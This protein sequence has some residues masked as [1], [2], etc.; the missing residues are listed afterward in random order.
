M[1]RDVRI[2]PG[3]GGRT[4]RFAFGAIVA[5]G[6]LLALAETFLRLSPP[7]DL[8]PYL[9]EASPLRGIYASDPEC[10]VTYQNWESFCTDNAERLSPY[11][12]FRNHPDG[13][14]LWAFFGNSFVQAPGMLADTTRAHVSD[15]T[16]F[17]LGRNE[18]LPLRFAQVKLLLARGLRPERIFFLLMPVDTVGLGKQPLDTLLV[19][20]RGALTY[21]LQAPSGPAGWLL[22]NSRVALTAWV[23][24]GRQQGNPHFDH[25]N[26]Y[27]MVDPVL[28]A[29]LQHLFA[30]L[31]RHGKKHGVPVTVL[32]VPAWHQVVRGESFGFQDTLGPILR[33]LGLD[34]FDPR[35]TF[36]KHPEPESLFLPDKHFNDQG[37]RILLEALLRHIGY[38]GEPPPALTDARSP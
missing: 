38:R 12:P 3:H 22:E 24:S 21:A 1:G 4:W 6:L 9:G 36:C 10:G 35:A 8:H 27:K 25:R 19:T 14:P 31:A 33:A 26:L 30:G 32:L 29:D 7:R 20:R 23:R 5:A 37:N 34:V 11:L 18:H 28:E 13:Q 17:N 2:G 16:V 15:R